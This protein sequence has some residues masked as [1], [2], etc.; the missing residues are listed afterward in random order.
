MLENI[1]HFFRGV[2]V[3][4]N[5]EKTGFYEKIE[6]LVD[7]YVTRLIANPDVPLFIL[8]EARNNPKRLPINFKLMDSYFMKQLMTEIKGGRVKKI[9]PVHLMMNILGLTI[10]PFAARPMVQR[11]RSISDKE[12]EVLMLERKKMIPRWIEDML[13]VK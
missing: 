4:V 6:Q 10:F 2:L 12:Y 11:V 7:F 13:K 3:I 1:G 9:N 8:N 5:D